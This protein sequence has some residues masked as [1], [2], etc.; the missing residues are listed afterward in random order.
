MGALAGFGAYTWIDRVFRRTRHG[1]GSIERRVHRTSHLSPIHQSATP[2]IQSANAPVSKGLCLL[3]VGA[4]FV[5]SYAGVAHRMTL[6][7][8]MD[9]SCLAPTGCDSVKLTDDQ[10]LPPDLPRIMR[11]EAWR[12]LTSQ[13]VFQETP[14][15][16]LGAFLIYTF[17]QLER[18]VS[19]RTNEWHGMVR[20]DDE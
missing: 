17:R 16:V 2:S 12:L 18:Q 3:V 6:R 8:Y 14:Q 1:W 11:G 9:G 5:S 20:D 19:G 15:T 13:L 10:F 7:T 4:S